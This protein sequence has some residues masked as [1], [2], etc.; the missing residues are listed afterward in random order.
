MMKPDE[1]NFLIHILVHQGKAYNSE[2]TVRRIIE[3]IGIN[4]KRAWYLLDKWAGR[5]WY[6]YGVC[7][8]L[9]W[10]TPEGVAYIK[11]IPVYKATGGL[12]NG[13]S[14]PVEP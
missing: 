2:P 8:D 4:H 5:G 14:M 10:L 3:F 7:I 1:Q 13:P 9:G 6:E 11:Q 12:M